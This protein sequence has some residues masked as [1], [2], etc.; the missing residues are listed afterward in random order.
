MLSVIET[1]GKQYTVSSGDKIKIEKLKAE[2]GEEVV[3]DKVLLQE[4]DGK[5]EVGR[6]YVQ[7][8]S[9]KAKVEKQAR[10]K[11]KIVFHYH[12]KTRYDKKKGHRQHFTEVVIG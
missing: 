12:A 4:K 9:V 10:D 2:P 11:K 1:G 6:P 8:A 3:F 5:V 7:G